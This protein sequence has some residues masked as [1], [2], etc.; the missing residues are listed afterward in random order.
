MTEALTDLLVRALS[1]SE[2]DDDGM[3]ERII[4]A[5]FAEFAESGTEGATMEG[6]AAR[7]GV[8]RMTV[9][10]RFGSKQQLVER[11]LIREF[12]R[13]LLDVDARISAIDDRADRVAEAFVLCVRAGTQH[14][15]L[16]RMTENAPGEMLE[17][18]TAG[19]PSPFELGRSYVAAR[20]RVDGAEVADADAAADVL[21]RLA[22]TYSLVPSQVV[23]VRDED[24]ARE[25]ARR[26]L[27]PIVI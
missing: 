8:G 9:F 24:A 27:A 10:R 19:S 16:A 12:R 6:V 17:R 5:A 23:D 2:A 11:V 26:V 13:F 15:L 25:F 22:I 20:I 7:A 21:V 4:D 3:E 14:P 1:T 18:M